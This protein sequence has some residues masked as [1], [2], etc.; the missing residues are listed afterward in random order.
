MG[1][2]GS[3][4]STIGA[5]LAHSLGW[6]F[7]DGDTFHP[8]ANIEKMTAGIPLT[9]DDRLP[10][11]D[12]IGSAVRK[13]LSERRSA[14]IACSALKHR[15]RDRLRIDAEAVAFVYLRAS[16]SVLLERLKHRQG[17]FMKADMLKSQLETLEEPGNALC[18]DAAE[19]P[20]QLVQEIKDKLGFLK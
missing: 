7:F 13:L 12:A 16:L 9:D 1:V 4:K 6:Q 19:P 17:H 15:Y 5:M 8:P 11:L 10:W 20:E 2:S 18:V 14:V 3:G